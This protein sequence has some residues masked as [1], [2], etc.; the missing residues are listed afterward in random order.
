MI[1]LALTKWTSLLCRDVT[2]WRSFGTGSSSYPW[3]K[4]L[5][6]C[7]L[8]LA[9]RLYRRNN[10]NK[11]IPDIVDECAFQSNEKSLQHWLEQELEMAL[12]VHEVRSAVEKQREE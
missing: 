7:E 4:F 1:L 8:V 2:P 5:A 6:E 3:Q 9:Y 11:P 12:R 10:I